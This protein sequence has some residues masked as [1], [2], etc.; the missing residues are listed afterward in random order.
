[1]TAAVLPRATGRPIGGLRWAARIFW[2]GGLMSYGMLFNWA[3]PSIYIPT[4][5]GGPTFQL[6]FFAA[7]GSYATHRSAA[8]FA[9]GNAVQVSVLAGV[10]GMTMAI[11]NERWFGTLPGLLAT[12][13]NRAALFAGRFIPFVFNGLLVSIYALA[14]GIIF[15][16]VRLAPSTIAVVALALLT[17]VFSCTA[18]GALQGAISLRLRDGLFGA[19]LIMMGVLLFCGVNIPLSELPGWMQFVGQLLPFTHG[20]QAI[21]QAA[22]G[23]GLDKVGGLI[24]IEALIGVVYAV[25]AF[26]LFQLLERS[27]RRNATLDVR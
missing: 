4:L 3:R 2:F 25:A 19:N 17:T 10:F 1:M 23:A 15:L 9:I 20:L 8:Y 26:A 24:A 16:G 6:F 11:A 27:A 13:A 18:I 12:P 21:R 22:D 14:I 5:I 7:L